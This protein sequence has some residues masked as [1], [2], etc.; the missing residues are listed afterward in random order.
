MPVLADLH[1]A[2]TVFARLR[3][4]LA[5]LAYALERQ[6][7]LDAADVVMQLDARLRELAGDG[8]LAVAGLAEAGLADDRPG[9]ATPATAG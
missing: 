4:E 7:R 9:S 2:P 8:G 3:T 1:P 5:D 6:G